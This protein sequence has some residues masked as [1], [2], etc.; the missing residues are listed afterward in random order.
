MAATGPPEPSCPPLE[1]ISVPGYEHANFEPVYVAPPAYELPPAPERAAPP[2]VPVVTE[3]EARTALEEWRADHCCSCCSICCYGKDVIKDMSFRDFISSSAIHYHLESWGES[4][5]TS[6]VTVPY[7]GGYIDG[8]HNGRAP[9]PWEV[10]V[11]TPR[12]M[13]KKDSTKVPVPHTE[14]VMPCHRCHGSGR[15]RCWSCHGR[16]SDDCFSCNSSGQRDGLNGERENCPFCHGRG[17]KDCIS[18]NGTGMNDC[19]TCLGAGQLKSYVQLK[20]KWTNDADD[21]VIDR[22]S[23]VP[24]ELISKVSGQVVVSEQAG[25][26]YPIRHFPDAAVNEACQRLTDQF[27]QAA[28][29]EMKRILQQKHKLQIVPV[30]KVVYSWKEEDYEYYVFGYEHKVYHPDYPQ[31]CCYCC[32]I[33]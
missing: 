23:N 15:D 32:T 16:G 12:E 21:S 29:T 5:S 6:Y 25:M 31:S 14:T 33:I 4:R 3:E 17:R 18:C 7:R 30:T 11:S 8:P 1:K 26:V 2:S 20:V 28:T 27:A 24:A 22:S 19:T 10:V 13:F 9:G